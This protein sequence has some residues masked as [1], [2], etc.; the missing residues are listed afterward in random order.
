MSNFFAHKLSVLQGVVVKG[1]QLGRTIGFPTANLEIQYTS[2]PSLN[3]VYS[4]YVDYKG[5]KYKGIMN[6][7]YKPTIEQLKP[8]KTFEV[9]I[10]NFDKEIYGEQIK[11]KVN[12]FIRNERKFK[13]LEELSRQ[14]KK[15]CQIAHSHFDNQK[16]TITSFSMNIQPNVINLPDLDFAQYCI[17]TYGINRGVYNTID[18]WFAE[19]GL[20]NI[21]S[22]REKI[23]QFLQWVTIYTPKD[24]LKFGNKGLSEQ[25]K[26]FNQECIK[27]GI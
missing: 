11:V 14:L 5:Q 7:G 6:I 23:V 19:S 15:D 21:V 9:H 26:R 2:F 24:K 12:S 18:K 13:S 8:Q 1:N 27:F 20:T 16:T 10:F 25:L 22:R 17:T 3:G 4:V